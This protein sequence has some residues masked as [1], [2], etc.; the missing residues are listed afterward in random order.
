M[1]TRSPIKWNKT[2]IKTHDAAAKPMAAA[3]FRAVIE[4]VTTRAAGPDTQINCMTPP[5]VNESVIFAAPLVCGVGKSIEL[6]FL[7][8]S[9]NRIRKNSC[10]LHVYIANCVINIKMRFKS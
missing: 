8:N 3:T 7:P 4:I 9:S 6:G 2:P 1:A 5:R 10:K